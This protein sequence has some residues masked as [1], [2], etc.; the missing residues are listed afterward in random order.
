MDRLALILALLVALWSPTARAALPV[1]GEHRVVLNLPGGSWDSQWMTD[2]N[3]F[4]LSVCQALLTLSQAV[5]GLPRRFNPNAPCTMQGS[6]NVNFTGGM[7]T[8]WGG[9]WHGDDAV[10]VVAQY[11]EVASCSGVLGR[12]PEPGDA[13]AYNCGRSEG[14][15][16]CVANTSTLPS[17]DTLP[18]CVPMGDS[19]FCEA[20]GARVMSGNYGDGVWSNWVN[21]P[22]F[23]GGS[24]VPEALP[25]PA[26]LPQGKCPGEVNGMAVVVD[27]GTT[28]AP[29]KG[30]ATHTVSTPDGTVTTSVTKTGDTVCEGEKC[31][32]T[33]TSTT[34]TKTV[35]PS[36]PS[37]TTTS[38][39]GTSTEEKPKSEFCKE[40]PR[41]K[42]C[43]SDNTS[44]S[45]SCSAKFQCSGGAAECAIAR[46]VN[47]ANCQLTPSAGIGE[48]A[49]QLSAGT[50]A[51]PLP[52][53]ART[54]GSFDT[55]NPLSGTCPGDQTF[56]VGGF[57]V[58]IP[59]SG[60]CDEL[61]MLGNLLVA[62]SLFMA[63]I[64]VVK[65]FA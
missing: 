7:Q 54:V 14:H 3:A 4:K 63:T 35:T 16:T 46:A 27:C 48:V 29:K 49:A 43:N 23:T 34:T 44:F 31:T 50:F 58:A 8:Y 13:T 64:F 28:S 41:D 5:D 17:G 53:V 6:P 39:T 55:S 9:A 61:Q 65:G 62:F 18:I 57:S 40:N 38:V 11:R 1:V 60:M 15:M 51:G 25:P 37:G 12:E 24:C 36:N 26:P 52:N 32:T 56:N 33:T 45:G 42:Q 30:T 47:E 2:L 10:F 21:D 22:K 20:S 19:Q 59:L